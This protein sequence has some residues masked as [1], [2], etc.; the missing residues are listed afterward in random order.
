MNECL[1]NLRSFNSILT[2]QERWEGV[3]KRLC[4]MKHRLLLKIFTPPTGI[5][6][7]AAKSAGQI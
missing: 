4:A 1:A 7:G 3:N 6:P 5:E 2:M